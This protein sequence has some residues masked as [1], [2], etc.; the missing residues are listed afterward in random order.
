MI[1]VLVAAAS[2]WVGT[3]PPT[4]EASE[5]VRSEETRGIHIPDETL[6]DQDGHPVRL[7]SELSGRRAVVVNFLFTT[8]STICSPMSAVFARL[9]REL[10]EPEG[11]DVLFLSVSLDPVR[12]TPERLKRFAEKFEPG[13]RPGWSFLTG[14]PERVKR[15]LQALGGWVPDKTSHTPVTLVGNPATGKWIRL[16]GMPTPSR[17]REALSEVGQPLEKT[18]EV[19][20]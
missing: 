11:K 6:V 18:A 10:G 14:E 4:P 15:V 20:R 13:P 9:R 12:D 3:A 1:L 17:L 19:Q 2:L 5:P 8:C 7:A 16:N